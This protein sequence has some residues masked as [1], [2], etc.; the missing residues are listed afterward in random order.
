M[1]VMSEIS[2]QIY[3]FEI[4]VSGED[5]AKQFKPEID[6]IT[7]IEEARTY[8]GEVRGWSDDSDLREVLIDLL[9][10]LK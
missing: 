10:T 4:E 7:T 2:K 9:L 8:Y 1:D 5:E 3:E 6:K